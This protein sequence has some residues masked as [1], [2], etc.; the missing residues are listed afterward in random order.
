MPKELNVVLIEKTWIPA[1]AG[2]TKSD[3]RQSINEIGIIVLVLARVF[4]A[5][6]AT[7][8]VISFFVTVDIAHFPHD[9]L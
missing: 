8:S 1:S 2:M 7:R 4:F 9:L 6:M 3:I 5:V